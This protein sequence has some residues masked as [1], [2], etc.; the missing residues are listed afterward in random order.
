M[1]GRVEARRQVKE[2]TM[3]NHLGWI[4][5]LM[6]MLPLGTAIKG[7]QSTQPAS[8]T[9]TWLGEL[10]SVDAT[11]RTLTARTRVAYQEALSELK[12]FKAGDAVWVAWSGVSDHSDAVRQF[13]RPEAN[14]KITDTLMMPAELVSPEVTNQY[15][16]LR[17][18]VPEAG[19]TA[20]KGVKPGEWITVTSRQRPVTDTD[21]VVAVKPYSQSSTAP[22]TTT[23]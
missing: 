22:T 12:Q 5:A 20:I 19:V 11:A 9:F 14:G 7:A 15:V 21:A 3:R 16:T 8:D 10:V 2:G 18:K 4:I 23:N 13:R 6:T 1:N 17:V